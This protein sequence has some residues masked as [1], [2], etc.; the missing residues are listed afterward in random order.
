MAITEQ[1]TLI[2]R[3]KSNRN[4]TA[5]EDIAIQIGK[6]VTDIVGNGN[7]S[8]GTSVTVKVIGRGNV[9]QST[10]I[11]FRIE[12]IVSHEEPKK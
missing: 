8:I 10:N 5:L 11:R 3:N 4:I 1:H 12:T 7:N 6:L 2:G 9:P